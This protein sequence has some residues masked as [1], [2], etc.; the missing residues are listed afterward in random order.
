MK[1]E[2][3]PSPIERIFN[4][5]WVYAVS[6]SASAIRLIPTEKGTEICYRIGDEWKTQMKLPAYVHGALVRHIDSMRQAQHIELRL[7]D[8]N[9]HVGLN[10][11]LRV[12]KT[13]TA[14]GEEVVLSFEKPQTPEYPTDDWADDVVF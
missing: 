11:R 14:Q 13:G 10:W 3:Q 9:F 7:R 1:S 8:E 2:L 4:T 6:D 5:I 12:E